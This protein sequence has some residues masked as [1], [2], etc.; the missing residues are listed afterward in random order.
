MRQ[1]GGDHATDQAPK[2][3]RPSA[4]QGGWRTV[5]EVE[6][7]LCLP[8]PPTLCPWGVPAACKAAVRA[9]CAGQGTRGG[10][11]EESRRHDA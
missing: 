7:A 2:T 5:P 1:G 6:P 9:R 8:P 11:E 3:C 10:D 4:A